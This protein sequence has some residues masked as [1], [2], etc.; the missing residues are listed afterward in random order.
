MKIKEQEKLSN[1][2]TIGLLIGFSVGPEFLKLPNLLVP[3]AG[4]DSWISAI[5][6]LIYPLLIV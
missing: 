2:Q 4:Q 5:A 6:A 3:S 1:G